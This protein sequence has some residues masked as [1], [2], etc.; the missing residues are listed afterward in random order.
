MSLSLFLD[1]NPFPSTSS[2][3]SVSQTPPFDKMLQGADVPSHIINA[4]VKIEKGE[5][6]IYTVAVA[7]RAEGSVKAEEGDSTP[8]DPAD[9][10]KGHFLKDD[11]MMSILAYTEQAP[12]F[13]ISNDQQTWIPL[14]S[15]PVF[16]V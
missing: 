3:L 9:Y 8:I 12:P 2:R 15:S 11:V 1:A 13:H 16:N 6:G 5:A 7:S 14:Y 10:P 4:A